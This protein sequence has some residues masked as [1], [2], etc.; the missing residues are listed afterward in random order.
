MALASPAILSGTHWFLFVVIISFIATLIWIS[1]YFLSIREAL[2]LPINWVLSVRIFIHFLI[3]FKTTE[4]TTRRHVTDSVFKMV[5][6]SVMWW[7][8]SWMLQHVDITF[9]M[10][11]WVFFCHSE[12]CYESYSKKIEKV[13]TRWN[14]CLMKSTF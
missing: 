10:L 3:T 14:I 13:I 5:N 4:H 1:I 2:V 12:A 8:C 9:E 7:V 11:A 6:N